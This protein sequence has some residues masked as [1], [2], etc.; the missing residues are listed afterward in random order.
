MFNVYNIY[1]I[2]LLDISYGLYV[3]MY[4]FFFQ[5]NYNIELFIFILYEIGMEFC[6]FNNCLWGDFNYYIWDDKDQIIFVIF[7]L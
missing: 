3:I 5:K 7:V 1:F 6:L 2:Y 4:E